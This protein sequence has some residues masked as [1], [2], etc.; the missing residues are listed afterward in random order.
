MISLYFGSPG[1]G[2]S[3]LGARIVYKELKNKESKYSC[4]YSNYDLCGTYRIKSSD[5]ARFAPAPHSLIIIDEAGID[6]NNRKYKDMKMSIIEFL[7]LYRHYKCD[8]V[9]ISQSWEDCDI[10]IRRLVDNL[11]YIRKLGPFT[12][13]RRIRKFIFI[14]KEKHQITEGYSFL[15]LFDLIMYLFNP[16]GRTSP[17]FVFYRRPYYFMFNSFSVLNRPFLPSVKYNDIDVPKHIY[18]YSLKCFFVKF[19]NK[20]FNLFNLIRGKICDIKR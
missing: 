11:I 2:K 5:L 18:I 13:C 9:F 7:K 8:I 4:I 14:E 20:I 12:F 6:F 3:T 16:I 1:S 17:F 19:K 15:G 10:T